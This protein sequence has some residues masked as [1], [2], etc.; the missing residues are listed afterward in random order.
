MTILLVLI[1]VIGIAI[2]LGIYALNAQPSQIARLLRIAAPIVLGAIG[3]ILSLAGRVAIGGPMIM[4]AFALFSR[5]RKYSGVSKAKG[6]QS[7]VRTAML[8]M[9]LDHDT[10]AMNGVV[11]AGSYEGD[12][13]DELSDDALLV[14]AAEMAGDHESMQ[15]LEAYLD[16]RMPE[17]R[18]NFEADAGARSAGTAQS[19]AMTHQEAYQILGIEEGASAVQIRKAHRSLMQRVHPD[20]GGSAFLAQRVN[21]AKD[22]LLRAHEDGS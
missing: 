14:L 13:L 19:G 10:G 18:D 5:L 4:L 3:I 15:L 20:V 1:G 22:F 2:L 17:W 7:T 16:R 21:E 9:M 11:L 8:E 12:V 6:Q